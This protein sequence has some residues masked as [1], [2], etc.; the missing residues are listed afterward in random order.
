MHQI[1]P[2][3]MAVGTGCGTCDGGFASTPRAPPTV[4]RRS[5]APSSNHARRTL[6]LPDRRPF[7]R[8]ALRAGRALRHLRRRLPSPDPTDPQP[9]RRPAARHDDDAEGQRAAARRAAP[10]RLAGRHAD[11]RAPRLAGRHRL[12]ALRRQRHRV[13]ADEPD[14]ATATLP[15]ALP[16][17]PAF[18]GVVLELQAGALSPSSNT[19]GLATSDQ[20]TMTLGN[21]R[22]VLR[23]ATCP[24]AGGE[25]AQAGQ[26]GVS[27]GESQP[28]R[29]TSSGGFGLAPS[30]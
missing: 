10:V 1:P 6:A 4:A 9:D 14:R 2:M 25:A 12:H 7:R 28:P 24:V 29:S 13:A 30:A 18:A 8:A 16:A 15:I 21:S 5:K 19:F 20:G 26:R 3:Q 11:Q 17:N 23:L 22:T 27:R